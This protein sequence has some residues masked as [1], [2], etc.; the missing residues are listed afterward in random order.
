MTRNIAL[1]RGVNVGGNN[2]IAM[3]E[4]KMALTATGLANVLTYINSRAP[5]EKGRRGLNRAMFLRTI[6]CR[7]AAF[8]AAKCRGNVFFESALDEMTAQRVCEQTIADTFGLSISVGIITTGELRDALSNAPDWWNTGANIK[9]NA[10]FVIAPASA[11]SVCAEVGEAKPEYEKIAYHGKVIFWSA[12]LP[13]FS[14]TRWSKLTQHRA[15]YN[16]TPREKGRRA[17]NRAMLLRTIQ[18]RFAAFF[19]AKCRAITIRN[20]NTTLKLLELA[21]ES[22]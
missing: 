16:R 6:Q 5:R 10:I 17:L 7:F 19:A 18:R 15:A 9:H 2:K 12:P 14:R 3:P 20:A 21:G 1:L 4:L 8:F 22:L 11:E 13:T